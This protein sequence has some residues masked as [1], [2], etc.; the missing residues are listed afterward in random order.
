M[1]KRRLMSLIFVA[2]NILGMGKSVNAM[3]YNND[4]S[5][6]D[7]TDDEEDD[8]YDE[9]E[10]DRRKS[11]RRKNTADSVVDAIIEHPVA[12][13]VGVLMLGRKLWNTHKENNSDILDKLDKKIEDILDH[14]KA[15]DC[16]QKDSF[17]TTLAK[18]FDN[19]AEDRFH[20]AERFAN[21]EQ[22]TPWDVALAVDYALQFSDKDFKDRRIL[23][24]Y[25]DLTKKYSYANVIVF[26][27]GTWKLYDLGAAYSYTSHTGFDKRDQDVLESYDTYK[28]LPKYRGNFTD[29]WTKFLPKCPFFDPKNSSSFVKETKQ[30]VTNITNLDD[31]ERAEEE[32]MILLKD[33]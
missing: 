22:V 15:I 20:A 32:K 19:R 18:A 7:E 33:E 27:N 23:V 8:E 4:Y 25:D 9:Y 5:D 28:V 14:G 3:G 1:N 11:R 24:K 26:P 31:D 21:D 13:G 16:K 2:S 17:G 12:T 6:S 10:N 30:D 29:T